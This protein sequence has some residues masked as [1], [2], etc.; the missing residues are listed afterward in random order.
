VIVFL[1][2][3]KF[4]IVS[5]VLKYFLEREGFVV[6][7]VIDIMDVLKNQH[8]NKGLILIAKLDPYA[9]E[10]TPEIINQFHKFSSGIKSTVIGISRGDP[11]DKTS[12]VL[13]RCGAKYNIKYPFK[14]SGLLKIVQTHHLPRKKGGL[15]SDNDSHY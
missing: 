7:T 2:A 9:K 12:E 3:Q 1:I 10:L 8:R 15:N 6:E 4:R 13:K 5:D 11:K 14:I